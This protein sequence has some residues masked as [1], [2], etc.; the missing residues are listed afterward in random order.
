LTNPI[1]NLAKETG[2][3]LCLIED[4]P[5]VFDQN[6]QVIGT[7]KADNHMEMVWSII[8]DAFKYSNEDCSNISPKKSL[9]D[10]FGEKVRE[11]GLSEEDQT[12]ILHMAEMW[13]AFIGD[14][15]EKQSL[16]YFW[17]EECLDG[18]KFNCVLSTFMATRVQ[19]SPRNQIVACCFDNV[20]I[21]W[22]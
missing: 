10:F 1:I 19:R 15:L 20:D 13:G 6:G 11:T 8:S 4:S 14:P 17:L 18:G 16:K 5:L 7:E 3:A 2:T 21:F 22:H 12:L 9:S